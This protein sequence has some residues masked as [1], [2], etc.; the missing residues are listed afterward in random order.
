MFFTY[1]M[2]YRING[3]WFTRWVNTQTSNAQKVIAQFKQYCALFSV[4]P[5]DI[6]ACQLEDTVQGV[7]LWSVI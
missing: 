7:R 3:K 1:K 2:I 5:S 4:A 6:I